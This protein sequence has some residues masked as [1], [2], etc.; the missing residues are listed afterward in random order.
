LNP[1]AIGFAKCHAPQLAATV[2]HTILSNR[3]PN[4]GVGELSI[5]PILDKK[6]SIVYINPVK[7]VI[8]Q[9]LVK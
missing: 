7:A 5:T 4:M 2:M 1:L 8:L 9:K 6:T 3:E